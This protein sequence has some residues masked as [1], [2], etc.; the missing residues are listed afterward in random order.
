[1]SA[2][3]LSSHVMHNI[4]RHVTC[5]TICGTPN[6]IAPEVLFDQKNG[7]SFEVDMW[8]LGVI[9]YTLLIGRPPFQT[10][11]VKAIYK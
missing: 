1:M 10:K 7:H 4:Y 8:S 3:A 9:L 5:R 11:E 6:Y 2:I